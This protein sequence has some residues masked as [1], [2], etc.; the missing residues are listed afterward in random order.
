MIA[1]LTMTT[2]AIVIL[3]IIG[4]GGHSLVACRISSRVTFAVYV[5]YLITSTIVATDVLVR[6]FEEAIFGLSVVIVPTMKGLF[7]AVQLLSISERVAMVINPMKGKNMY[8]LFLGGVM[9]SMV[10][11]GQCIVQ[12]AIFLLLVHGDTTWMWTL[13]ISAFNIILMNT[14]MTAFM[15]ITCFQFLRTNRESKAR[16]ILLKIVK[17]TISLLVVTVASELVIIQAASDDIRVIAIMTHMMYGVIVTVI[18]ISPPLKTTTIGEVSMVNSKQSSVN[19]HSSI[20]NTRRIQSVVDNSKP[21]HIDSTK[22]LQ[23][24]LC[25]NTVCTQN[26][27]TTESTHEVDAELVHVVGNKNVDELDTQLKVAHTTVHIVSI[28][29]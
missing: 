2:I 4:Y 9:S 19:N 7:H 23:S 11:I 24:I 14:V 8:I 16:P 3:L 18:T 20:I 1:D 29:L 28:W 17:L 21:I 13:N 26:K 22:R 12:K 5:V 15:V 25:K 10:F 27:L 6:R